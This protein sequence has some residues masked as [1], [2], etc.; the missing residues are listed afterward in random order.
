[1]AGRTPLHFAA[2]YGHLE[3]VK[4]QVERHGDLLCIQD[5][6]GWTLL[7]CAAARGHLEVVKCQVE[8][9]GDLLC[10]QDENGRTPLDYSHAVW[11]PRGGE[12]AGQEGRR[13][14]DCWAC[15]Y[16]ACDK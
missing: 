5:K 15:W 2:A 6:D 10:M 14:S 13:C 9:R 8:R 4:W 12:V 11:P 3:V 1:M 16:G 7:Y